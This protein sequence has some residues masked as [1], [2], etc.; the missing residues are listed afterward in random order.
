MK[1]DYIRD[2]TVLLTL[3]GSRAYGMHRPDSDV[4]LKGIA[5][6]GPE[7]YFANLTFEQADKPETMKVFLPWLTPAEQAIAAETKLEGTVYEARKF[8]KLASLSNP[9]ILDVLFCRDEDVRQRTYLGS[10]LREN[11][12]LFIS[13]KCKHTF[14]GYA[15]SQMRR[16]RT[17]RRW[18]LEKPDHKP[19]RAEFGLPD[20]TL[21]PADQLKGAAAMMRMKM[22][23]WEFDF[24]II[25]DDA[26]RIQLLEIIERT[27]TEVV[28]NA[29]DTTVRDAKWRAASR[30][31]GF[32]DNFLHLLDQERRYKG[33]MDEWH[34][35]CEWE[36]N[37]NR[38]RHALEALYG[39]D[40]KHAA[41]LV[42]LMRMGKE[43]LNTGKVNV[44]RG[45]IDAEELKGIRN[46]AWTF[47]QLDEF[48]VA[49]DVELTE[50]YDKKQYIIP[51]S[52]DTK[53][54]DKVLMLG[55]TTELGLNRWS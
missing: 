30:G 14:S 24:S 15:A 44:W 10:L 45:D 25:P 41:H 36:K 6:P 17:H 47:E 31:L 3:A 40:T 20:T 12:N 9:N 26:D 50:I 37:R 4:D 2:H 35:F 52:P 8:T 11:R 19:T 48:F 32:D 54:I 23:G 42:R 33:A 51:H 29:Q 21:V 13:A 7:Y 1:P 18:L 34:S 27:L 39:Y 22:D 46:G 38:D 16:I 28:V 49:A 43:I 53:A 5:V 55:I